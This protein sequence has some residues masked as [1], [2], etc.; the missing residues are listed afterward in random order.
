VEWESRTYNGKFGNEDTCPK[1]DDSLRNF[2]FV[3]K[4]L[5]NIPARRYALKAE[6]K[7]HAISRNSESG[8][9]FGDI[10]VSDN[11]NA[12]TESYAWLDIASTDDTGL[13]EIT[14]FTALCYFQ[15]K[16]IEVFEIAE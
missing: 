7:L 16:E 6:K 9:C 10:G 8:P 3:L 11:C 15:V 2:L 4:N 13:D 14:V 5:Q 1:T 12:D